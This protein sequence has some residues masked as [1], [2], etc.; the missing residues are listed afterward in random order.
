YAP[1]RIIIRAELSTAEPDS[2]SFSEHSEKP[3][4]FVVLSSIFTALLVLGIG[5]IYWLTQRHRRRQ[6]ELLIHSPIFGLLANTEP[7]VH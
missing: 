7:G 1:G 5:V 6:Y 3:V 4:A 2:V